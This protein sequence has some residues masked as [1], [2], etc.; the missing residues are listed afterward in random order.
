MRSAHRTVLYAVA[1]TRLSFTHYACAAIP[2][3]SPTRGRYPSTRAARRESDQ[4]ERT[5]PSAA[6]PYLATTGAPVTLPK[7]SIISFT[8]ALVP[9]PTL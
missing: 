1:A 9:P 3:S 4:V 2:S 8:V 5:S 7:A 6:G